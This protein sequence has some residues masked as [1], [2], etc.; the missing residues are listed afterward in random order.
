MDE[1]GS[2]SLSLELRLSEPPL[3]EV[4]FSSTKL[5]FPF[6]LIAVKNKNFCTPFVFSYTALTVTIHPHIAPAN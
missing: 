3:Q 5:V 6:A 1:E 4:I 2:F